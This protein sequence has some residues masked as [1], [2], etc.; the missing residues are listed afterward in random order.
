MSRKA[1]IDRAA[2]DAFCAKWPCHGI[3]ATLASITFEFATN[4]DLVDI[5]A[6]SRNGRVVDS[7]SFDGPALA[8]LSQD[9]QAQEPETP[10]LFRKMTPRYGGDV[11]AVF[12]CDAASY[13]AHE[14]GSYAHVGQHGACDPWHVIKHS[15]PATPAEYADLK[16]ELESAPFHYRLRV[17]ARMQRDWLEVRRKVL[18]QYGAKLPPS[19]PCRDEAIG[20]LSH[21]N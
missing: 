10:V 20:R 12:P 11:L 21:G 8:A 16:A 18:A 19:S 9:A 2:I 17:Y 13:K 15:H 5:I 4:G 14:C 6:K 1:I 3:P 7:A